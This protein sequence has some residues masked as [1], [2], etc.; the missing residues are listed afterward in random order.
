M[1]KINLA[2]KFELFEGYWS[3]RIVGELNGQYIKLAKFKG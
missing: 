3:P 2:D 1:E